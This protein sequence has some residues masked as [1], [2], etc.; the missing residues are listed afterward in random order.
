MPVILAMDV[1]VRL[2]KLISWKEKET[3]NSNC[4]KQSLCFFPSLTKQFSCVLVLSFCRVYD[5]SCL[6]EELALAVFQAVLQLKRLTPKVL[7]LFER[8]HHERVLDVI[9]A[10]NIQPL[11]VLIKFDTPKKKYF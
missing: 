5:V 1:G 11:P 8:S 2:W 10:L 7:D 4:Q 3:E 9:D 6:P